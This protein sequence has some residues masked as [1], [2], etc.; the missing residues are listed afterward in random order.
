MEGWIRSRRIAIA[1]SVVLVLA[2]MAGLLASQTLAR[3]PAQQSVRASA[4]TPYL[5]AVANTLR[6]RSPG[7]EGRA[8]WLSTENELPSDW[9]LQ[10]PDCWGQSECSVPPPGG[11]RVL[12]RMREMIASARK[13][14]DI[15]ELYEQ[16]GNPGSPDHYFFNA[17][18]DGLIDGHKAHPGEVPTVR[19]LIGIYPGAI[20]NPQV[21]IDDLKYRVGSWVKVQSGAMQSAPFSWNH[22]KI[23]DVD[24]REAIVGGMN[25]W[26][27]DY[28][29]THPVNDISM[30]VKGPA[31]HDI[32]P[33]TALLWTYS[34]NHQ[35]VGNVTRYYGV[36]DCI[37]YHDEGPA[38]RYLDG[39]PIMVVTK[40]GLNIDVP[41]K[42]GQESK[43]IDR[44]PYH[45]GT[46]NHCA[47][48]G[49]PVNES[50][51]YEYRNPGETALR[52][53]IGSAKRSIFISQ[54]DL[55]SCLLGTEAMLDERVFAALADKVTAHVPIKI[56]LTGKAKTYSNGWP[57]VYVA[58]HLAGMLQKQHDLSLKTAR[59]KICADVGLTA[60]R[61]K[62]SAQRWHDGTD[63]Y[64]HAKVV[65]VDDEAFYIGSENLY[66]ARLQELG[67]I[68]DNAAA[69]HHLDSS[70]LKPLWSSSQPAFMDPASKVCPRF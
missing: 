51:A 50:R 2:A 7:T 55:L 19:L 30:E 40:L 22:A 43:P 62:A 69:A 48:A 29:G 67:L 12:G 32:E 5:D 11:N 70:Y 36:R 14:V 68:V 56:V 47:L 64:N 59:E 6:D 3:R 9:L 31:A 8:W 60:I 65:A 16:G 61:N 42:A 53:L 45:S 1:G 35:G 20:Y 24:G 21:F 28:L 10:T 27:S 17:I 54:Q 66:P 58:D 15:A 26:S 52:A 4:A 23:L 39:I 49:D 25:Y 63:F 37:T 46:S 44:P 38:P 33:Y 41:N 57:L 34:C 13:F 18:A